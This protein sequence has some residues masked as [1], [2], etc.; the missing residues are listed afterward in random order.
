MNRNENKYQIEKVLHEL[1]R[2]NPD[3]RKMAEAYNRGLLDTDEALG[4]ISCLIK[5]E[6]SRKREESDR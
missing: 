2:D 3:I 1:I 6:K 4:H 5:I